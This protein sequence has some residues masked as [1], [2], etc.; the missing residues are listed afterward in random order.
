MKE[1]VNATHTSEKDRLA[2]E[3]IDRWIT[4]Q[5]A[6]SNKKEYPAGEFRAFA[7]SVRRY[8]QVVGRDPMIHREVATAINGLVDFLTVERGRIPDAVISEASRLESLF[9]SGYDPHFEGDEPRDL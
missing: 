7:T 3:V 5:L 1:H 4:F 8:V 2:K 6:L 9:F